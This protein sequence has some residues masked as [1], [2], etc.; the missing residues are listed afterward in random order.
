MISFAKAFE[1]LFSIISYLLEIT[2]DV[3]LFVE[4][5]FERERE[6]EKID[7]FI[8]FTLRCC[9]KLSCL[10]VF[11]ALLAFWTWR[12]LPLKHVSRPD[13]EK[14]RGDALILVKE[15]EAQNLALEDDLV[16]TLADRDAYRR[17]YAGIATDNVILINKL[18]QLELQPDRKNELESTLVNLEDQCRDLEHRLDR[19]RRLRHHVEVEHKEEVRRAEDKIR[20][21]ETSLKSQASTAHGY[22]EKI[23]ELE[24][25]L[26]SEPGRSK[27]EIEEF[28][29]TLESQAI[30]IALYKA[31][32]A[33]LE[34]EAANAEEAFKKS[35]ELTRLD[36][37][38]DQANQTE[39]P[40]E[41]TSRLCELERLLDATKKDLET[42][43]SDNRRHQLEET[44]RAQAA[45]VAMDQERKT[46]R[47]QQ[48]GTQ[49]LRERNAELERA[50]ERLV[51]EGE[52]M[53]STIK[54]LQDDLEAH[55]N[56]MDV[57]VVSDHKCDHSQCHKDA[58]LSFEEITNLTT[59]LMGRDIKVNQ[60]QVEATR[61]RLKIE[62]L[63]GQLDDQKSTVEKLQNF[64]DTSN[65]N[66]SQL[67]AS[68][69]LGE[70]HDF[71]SLER[72]LCQ[73]QASSAGQ[74]HT[75]DHSACDRQQL[76]NS[77]EIS[78]LRRKESLLNAKVD[79]KDRQVASATTDGK[80]AFG[81]VNKALK[82]TR[83]LLLATEKAL[84]DEKAAR[85]NAVEAERRFARTRLEL[86]NPLR[87]DIVRLQKA[88]TEM[89]ANRDQCRSANQTYRTQTV[90]ARNAVQETEKAQQAV[91]R[92]RD[93]LAKTIGQLDAKMARMVEVDREGEMEGIEGSSGASKK[94]QNEGEGDA[95][96]AKILRD[97]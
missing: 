76:A 74:G 62:G 36:T 60:L 35:V 50:S 86:N 91:E 66:W 59:N 73:W 85:Q 8:A 28:R 82:E 7:D 26:S 21:L 48:A 78:D 53:R 47:D 69:Q 25:A 14:E 13:L 87:E 41:S 2:E 27:D 79:E 4:S 96:E 37:T 1:I 20:K 55:N 92:Q 12:N 64:V 19:S 5:H 15:L 30:T 94:R 10:A 33:E 84:A 42:R 72:L 90:E 54:K 29:A 51:R 75:C 83:D 95:R 45:L 89:T 9:F 93:G 16:K 43:D 63:L 81:R 32:I 70:G 46:F 97:E 44:S 67:T 71:A 3:Y 56:A 6:F 40:E 39:M 88:L 11:V 58:N 17:D 80:K 24:E 52:A 49:L 61:Q 38:R 22:K 23:A 34:K 57:D 77:K 18:N 65:R 31:K 68:L